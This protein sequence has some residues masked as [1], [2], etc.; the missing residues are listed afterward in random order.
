MLLGIIC[1]GQSLKVEIDT[2]E[3]YTPY[4][5]DECRSV[6]LM[7]LEIWEEGEQ[8]I[9]NRVE[10]PTDSSTIFSHRVALHL[11]YLPK[12]VVFCRFACSPNAESLPKIVVF[13]RTTYRRSS[14]F[15]ASPVR[16]M[17]LLMVA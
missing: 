16:P 2:E 15:A 3:D 12:I 6:D 17:P 14:S 11:Y 4:E 13:C 10:F 8:E 5:A 9:L 1:V 7:S